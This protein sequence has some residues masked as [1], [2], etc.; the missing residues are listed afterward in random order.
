[1][2][3]DS[4]INQSIDKRLIEANES[5]EEN[6]TPSGKLSA[7]MLYQPL[8]FQ[9][10][11]TLGAPRKELDPYVLGKFKRGNDVEDWFVDEIE[12]AG[13]LIERQKEVWYKDVIGYADAMIDTDKMQCKL[14]VM[15]LEVKSVTNA[16]LRQ[17]KKKDV[18]YHWR[19][20]A[21]MYA[22]GMEMGHFALAVV[23]A[24]DLRPTVYVFKTRELSGDVEQAIA[25]YNQAL[26]E[27]E[28]KR[29][30]PAFE[31]HPEVKW[32][33]DLKY[34]MFE[35]FW[36]TAPDSEVIKRLEGK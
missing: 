9:V 6:R 22:M 1:M 19:L 29:V 14:G 15:P 32:T 13:L 16:K 2:I 25:R 31:P 18:D 24:E 33:Q 27:W 11:K 21:T 8:R 28:N 4:F 17:L 30:L 36:A 5:R 12:H 20:Q 23:S 26:R 10:L 7:S 3:I 35:P 34:A